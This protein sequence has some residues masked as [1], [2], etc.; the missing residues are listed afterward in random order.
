M[1]FENFT[2]RVKHSWIFQKIM[3]FPSQKKFLLEKCKF[4]KYNFFTHNIIGVKDA[5]VLW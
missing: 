2:S 4:E 1:N 3:Y 5:K